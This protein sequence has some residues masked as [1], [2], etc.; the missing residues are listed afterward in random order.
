MAPPVLSAAQQRAFD[1]LAQDF[2]RVFAERFV[3]L[4]A[5]GHGAGLAFT[6]TLTFKD[7]EA[8]SVL[9]D[10]WHRQGLATPLVMTPEEFTRSLDCFPLEYQSILDAHVVI[11]GVPPFA[12]VMVATDDLRRGC[13]AQAKGHLIHLRQACLES[14]GHAKGL[15]AKLV[16]SAAPL[17]A[18]LSSVAR[19]AGAAPAD[20]AA[21]SAFAAETVG[22]PRELV[23]RILRLESDPSEAAQV[24]RL[25]AE[26][27][28]A[29]ERLWMF[30]DTW[31]A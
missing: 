22:M 21:L 10:T 27:L 8:C 4:V 11:A 26:Y 18:L 14:G 1:H 24:A 9:T 13:E 7:L 23:E 6:T 16:A 28:S 2:Q 5:Y 25:F 30:I 20:N 19:L 31:H 15:R 29:A 12:G 3:A 17:R